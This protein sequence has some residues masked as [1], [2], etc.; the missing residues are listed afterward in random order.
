[1][2]E[3]DLGTLNMRWEMRLGETHAVFGR[4]GYIGCLPA[5]GIF[6]SRIITNLKILKSLLLASFLA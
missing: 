4:E 2:Q 1:M 5:C 3:M 6:F